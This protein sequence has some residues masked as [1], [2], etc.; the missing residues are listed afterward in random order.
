MTGRG[1][2]GPT[3]P[4]GVLTHPGHSWPPKGTVLGAEAGST[5]PYCL[6]LSNSQ[7]PADG[8]V[9]WEGFRQKYQNH[10]PPGP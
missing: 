1:G 9:G 5:P 2:S 6:L 3:D 7:V 10:F 8:Q 4:Q